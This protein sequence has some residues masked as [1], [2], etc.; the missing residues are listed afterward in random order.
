M[1]N[2]FYELIYHVLLS[3]LEIDNINNYSS[4]FH[5]DVFI[6]EKDLW[7]D[8]SL[9]LF[10][11]LI[12][13]S[14]KL[15]IPWNTLLIMDNFK[16]SKNKWNLNNLS[17]K[18]IIKKFDLTPP[19]YNMINTHDFNSNDC[20][21]L[22]NSKYDFMPPKINCY[23]KESFD[24][25]DNSYYQKLIF[26]IDSN[27]IFEYMILSLYNPNISFY[28]NS[29]CIRDEEKNRINSLKQDL[30][31]KPNNIKLLIELGILLLLTLD[32]KESEKVFK[33]IIE[34][35]P[36]N[37]EAALWLAIYYFYYF[38]DAKKAVDLISPKIKRSERPDCLI[39][40]YIFC[41]KL[42]RSNEKYI[43]YLILAKEKAP[44]WIMPRILY[45]LYLYQKYIPYKYGY[46]KDK[47]ESNHNK[48]S[49]L[50]K[51]ELEELVNIFANKQNFIVDKKDIIKQFYSNYITGNLQENFLAFEILKKIIS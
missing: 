3:A 48:Y 16:F 18:F 32:F 29:I 28:S 17:K 50:A 26:E 51:Q 27:L 40:M 8:K 13:Q 44:D 4:D 34:L 42:Y 1:K 2:V 22:N 35:D 49:D 47:S 10:P 6:D 39:L 43:D 14:K 21:K 24:K 31:N 9:E 19:S 15:M 41:R 20:I 23:F 46:I 37:I 36:E 25:Y 12:L 30:K 11:L 45:I 33:R 5:V 38:D 7:F